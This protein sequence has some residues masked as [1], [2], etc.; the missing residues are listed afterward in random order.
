MSV[1]VTGLSKQKEEQQKLRETFVGNILQT[2]E[3]PFKPPL[4]PE[5]GPVFPRKAWEA[6]FKALLSTRA[7]QLYYGPSEQGKTIAVVHAL[8]NRKGVVYL[9][10]HE[11]S[12]EVAL[13]KTLTQAF[14]FTGDRLGWC[15]FVSTYNDR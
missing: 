3:Q 7:Y 5:W 14:N 13:V 11:I 12:N 6:E 15:L 2:L 8:K 4:E 9:R 10:L 1:V